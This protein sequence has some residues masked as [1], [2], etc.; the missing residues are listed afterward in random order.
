MTPQDINQVETFF[1]KN[2]E[3]QGIEHYTTIDH[4]SETLIETIKEILNIK[5][6]E[7]QPRQV[8]D[9]IRTFHSLISCH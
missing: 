2:N 4:I 9:S 3:M 5:T 8:S 7:T 1:N 6:D